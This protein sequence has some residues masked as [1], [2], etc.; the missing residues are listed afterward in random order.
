MFER[1]LDV[2]YHVANVDVALAPPRALFYRMLLSPTINLNV[3]SMEEKR[4]L[5]TLD[6]DL[7]PYKDM[8]NEDI[9]FVL[10][11]TMFYELQLPQTFKISDK[12]LYR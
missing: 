4:A 9:L 10:L 8:E 1:M 3:L 5:M 11:M 6:F 2:P 7:F 12:T